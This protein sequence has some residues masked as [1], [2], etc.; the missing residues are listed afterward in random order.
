MTLLDTFLDFLRGLESTFP[1][2]RTFRIAQ[3]QAI[4]TLM[5]LGQHTI[6]RILEGIGRNQ[7][8]WSSDYRLYSR[9]P[10]D[11]RDLFQSGLARTIA[12]SHP[13]YLAVGFDDTRLHK[14]G[15]HIK[16]A[17]FAR[18]P[19]SPPFHTNLTLGLR[20]LQASA[21]LPLYREGASAA[22]GIPVR[23]T[24]VPAIKKPGKNASK[25]DMLSYREQVKIH[26][27]SHHSVTV[28]RDLRASYD[29]AGAADKLLIMVGD[30]SFCNRT[31]LSSAIPRTTWLARCRKDAV[32]CL[33]APKSSRQRV[34]AKERFTPNSIRTD[35]SIPWQTTDIFHGGA[36]R[37]VRFKQITPVLWPGG[38][39]RIPLRLIVI[40][41][42][43]YR[44]TPKG[45]RYYRQPAFL[46]TTDLLTPP[47]LLIQMYFDRWEI[48]VNHR[49]EKSILGV[50]QAQVRSPQSVPRQ[51][52]FAVAVYALIL[53]AALSCL[54]PNRTDAYLPLPKWRKYARRPSL[55]DLIAILRKEI[56]ENPGR[57][58]AFGVKTSAKI[59]LI[60]A[61]A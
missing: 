45:K 52:A 44:C 15:R 26:N 17:F 61:A 49:D 10:W 7:E 59:L 46:L 34:Y 21:L 9:S 37:P 2:Y 3:R 20:F 22:R 35:D 28:A 50:G 16:T 54:G 42:T 47:E 8:S 57:V 40:A 43:P 55:L 6:S 41:P 23:F 58:E 53:L 24:E 27:L 1:Q 33:P 31:V 13:Q 36:K 25:E 30:G 32:L 56:V 29:A 38:T 18:D 12:Y 14:T 19:L 51:P 39:Q 48:E 11:Q 5:I 4:G 60:T